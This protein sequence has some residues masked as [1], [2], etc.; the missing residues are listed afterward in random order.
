MMK[1]HLLV[2]VNLC[3]L[4]YH[5]QHHLLQLLQLAQHAK[6]NAMSQLQ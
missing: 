2:R 6:M 3:I 5:H 4:R 1:R